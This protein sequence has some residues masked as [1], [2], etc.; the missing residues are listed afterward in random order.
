M[1]MMK[2]TIN[3][4]FTKKKKNK[5]ISFWIWYTAQRIEIWGFTLGLSRTLRSAEPS[6]EV[7][8]KYALNTPPFL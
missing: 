3:Q 1:K 6:A 7:N 4:S 2:I 5:K 8:R